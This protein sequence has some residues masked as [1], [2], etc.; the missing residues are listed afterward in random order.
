MAA[1][2]LLSSAVFLAGM[3]WSVYQ[4]ENR[5]PMLPSSSGVQV[6]VGPGGGLT[7]LV[8]LLPALVPGLLL[9]FLAYRLPKI[10]RLR[11]PKCPWSARFRIRCDGVAVPVDAPPTQY[12]EPSPRSSAGGIIGEFEQEHAE[13][14]EEK[15]CE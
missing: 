8:F 3:A 10:L 11:C 12:H 7:G 5:Q 15:T 4:R 14:A 6:T 1:G 2:F 9:G 13:D